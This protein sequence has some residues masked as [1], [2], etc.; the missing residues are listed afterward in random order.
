LVTILKDDA[1]LPS[2]SAQRYS[3][4]SRVVGKE[5]HVMYTRLR[6]FVTPPVGFILR[7]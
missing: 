7:S 5:H 3:V 6:N 1:V 2:C 4:S